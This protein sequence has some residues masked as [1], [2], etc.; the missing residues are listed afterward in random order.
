M[1][2]RWMGFAL[3]ATLAAAGCGSPAP[4]AP[5]ALD[6]P[7]AAAAATPGLSAEKK[8]GAI[9]PVDVG[10]T[11]HPLNAL[12][13]LEGWLNDAITTTGSLNCGQVR[14]L[15][16][17]LEAV[18]K[19]LDRPSPNFH[20]ACGTSGALVNELRALVS[21]GALITPT[22]MP[23][24]PG[25]PTN[26]VAAAEGLNERWCAAAEGEVVGPRS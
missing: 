19:A 2:S 24:F 23:P 25:G 8:V 6:A 18:T 9:C 21:R 5:G 16:A 4:S 13:E 12:H 17:K 3:A 20:A 1:K 14:S 10:S 7:G 22:F 11:E 15:D 26:V